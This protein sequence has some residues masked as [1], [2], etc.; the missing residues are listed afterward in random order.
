MS[1]AYILSE[2]RDLELNIVSLHLHS[3]VDEIPY[4]ELKILDNKGDDLVAKKI[5]YFRQN[6]EI[7]LDNPGEDEGNTGII[8]KGILTDIEYT[9]TNG[10]NHYYNLRIFHPAYLMTLSKRSRVFESGTKY[11]SAIG[12]ICEDYSEIRKCSVNI[13]DI[14]NNQLA[15]INITDWDFI[16]YLAYRSLAHIIC[17]LDGIEVRAVNRPKAKRE[18]SIGDLSNCKIISSC[19]NIYSNIEYLSQDFEG[20]DILRGS[21]EPKT[22]TQTYLKK[23]ESSVENY[24]FF[25]NFES[26]DILKKYASNIHTWSNYSRAKLSFKTEG[27]K[28][29]NLAN[30]IELEGSV[31][32]GIHIITNIEHVLEEGSWNTIVKAGYH[33]TRHLYVQQKYQQAYIDLK[34]IKANVES[35][36]EGEKGY[37]RIK[38]S[39][40]MPGSN[41]RIELWA[42]VHQ[43]NANFTILPDINQK[44]YL[45]FIGGDL[46]YPIVIGVVPNENLITDDDNNIKQWK[47]KNGAIFSMDD[48]NG[49]FKLIPKEKSDMFFEIN[50]ED[51]SIILKLNDSCVLSFDYRNIHAKMNDLKFEA[52]NE[53]NIEAFNSTIH[54]NN[55]MEISSKGKFQQYAEIYKASSNIEFSIKSNGQTDIKGAIIKLN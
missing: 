22:N 26:D 51:Q 30:K 24:L 55:N 41:G 29:Y 50:E 52:S 7:K 46:S 17:G 20:K 12:N 53:L 13:E 15:Q 19:K 23:R 54:S 34:Y 1:K 5:I 4:C 37:R 45:D 32:E 43:Q 47:G 10:L 33:K 3:A 6:I 11:K 36:N 44:V 2:G 40:E 25:S 39:F 8:F 28:D 48:A 16:L 9:S 14:T 49:I 27:L 42:A 35:L 38:V 31:A 21:S 18:L